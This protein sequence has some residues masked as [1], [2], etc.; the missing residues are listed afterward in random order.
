LATCPDLVIGEL[1]GVCQVGK[2]VI[3]WSNFGLIEVGEDCLDA[4]LTR[5][6]TAFVATHP[7]T[8]HRQDPLWEHQV[9]H[10]VLV[11]QA[12]T[13]DITLLCDGVVL[14]SCCFFVCACII[15]YFFL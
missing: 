6:L 15:V 12:F 14:I 8:Y 11:L 13:T 7:I 4:E 3:P 1:N 9:T 5:D 2:G 10:K